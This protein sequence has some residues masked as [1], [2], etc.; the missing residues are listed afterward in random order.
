[1]PKPPVKLFGFNKSAASSQVMSQDAVTQLQEGADVNR[2]RRRMKK[3]FQ[4]LRTTGQ[5][6][7]I[8]VAVISLLV[9]ITSGGTEK[10]SSLP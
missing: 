8:L 7:I 4:G 9:A 5:V 1:M 6:V 2:R 10:N 3:S